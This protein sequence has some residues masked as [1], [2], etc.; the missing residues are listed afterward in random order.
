MFVITDRFLD[1]AGLGA[2]PAR[3]KQE[4]RTS[5]SERLYAAV[6][7]RVADDLDV[8]ETSELAAAAERGPDAERAWLLINHPEVRLM[9]DL[10]SRL[11]AGEVAAAAP[12]LLELELAFAADAYDAQQSLNHPIDTK[13]Q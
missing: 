7:E 12:E 9:A 10:E 1:E 3:V 6:I 11:L 2:L 8:D 13:E 4:Y 5:L